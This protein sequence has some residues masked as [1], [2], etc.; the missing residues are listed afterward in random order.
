MDESIVVCG[1]RSLC[2]EHSCERVSK[3]SATRRADIYTFQRSDLP[4]P[5][6]QEAQSVRLIELA[7]KI[8]AVCMCMCEAW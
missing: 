7:G 8:V 4:R 2:V 3:Q 6:S 1:S 5:L